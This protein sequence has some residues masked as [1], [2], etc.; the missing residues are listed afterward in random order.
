MIPSIATALLALQFPEPPTKSAAAAPASRPFDGYELPRFELP[1]GSMHLGRAARPSTY[2]D[3]VGSR[4]FLC[5][6]EDGGLEAWIWPWQIFVDGRF[7]FRPARSLEAFDLHRYAS[8][9][10]VFP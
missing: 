1:T 5:G 8:R 10:D 2:F 4:S 7:S 3:A 9:I 6:S